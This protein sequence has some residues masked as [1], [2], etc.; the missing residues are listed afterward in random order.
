MAMSE[1]NITRGHGL[2]EIF[3]AKKRAKKVNNLIP[4]KLREGRILDIGC[5]TIPFFLIN[6]GFREKYGIDPSVRLNSGRGIILK[7]FDV[8]RNA[9]LPFRDNFFDAVTMLAVFE[10]IE[11]GRLAGV[12]REIKRVLKPGGRFIMTTP[13]P[14]TDRLLRVMARLGLVSARE[15]EEHKGA[16]NRASIKRYLGMAGFAQERMGFGYFEFFLNNWAYADK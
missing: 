2:L 16:Y 7:G 12:L 10:H 8:E 14:W 13:C 9:R 15:M 3:L 5:G 11:P 4:E 1:S 6:T